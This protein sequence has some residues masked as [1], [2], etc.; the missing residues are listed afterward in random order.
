MK[1]NDVIDKIGVK[2][3]KDALEILGL[4]ATV[5]IALMTLNVY[6]K[7][8]QLDEQSN[9][10]V[11]EISVEKVENTE[12]VYEECL[13]I[14]NIGKQIEGKEIDTQAVLFLERTENE[15]KSTLKNIPIRVENYFYNNNDM[16]ENGNKLNGVI[17]RRETNFNYVDIQN[18]IR[19]ISNKLNES[20]DKTIQ[21]YCNFSYYIKISYDN[22]DGKKINTYYQVGRYTNKEISKQEYEKIFELDTID[23]KQNYHDSLVDFIK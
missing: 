19:K 15:D 9:K 8:L 17:C 11:F 13:Q 1:C 7:Q 23:V 18:Q 20:Y 21:V 10:P 12:G 6:K 14:N 3:V 4:A 5:V 22:Y 16:I 2:N